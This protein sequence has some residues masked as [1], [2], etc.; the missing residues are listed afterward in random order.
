M[1]PNT[2][3]I[4]SYKR[5]DQCKG[6]H[7]TGKTGKMAQKIP[8]QGKHREFGNTIRVGTLKAVLFGNALSLFHCLIS[9]TNTSLWSVPVAEPTREPKSETRI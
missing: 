5:R 8:C 6:N 1:E 9:T 7:G 2:S 4:Y 3:A